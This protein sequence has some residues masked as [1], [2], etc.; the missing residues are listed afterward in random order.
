LILVTALPLVATGC[1]GIS[2]SQSISPATFFLPGLLRAT[3]PADT[4]HT[5]QFAA[6]R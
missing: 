5:N 3:P 4:D 1:G 6:A 2:G